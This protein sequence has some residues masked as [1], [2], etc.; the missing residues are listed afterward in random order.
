M[1]VLAGIWGGVFL[2]MRR[3]NPYYRRLGLVER[4]TTNY[5]AT[6]WPRMVAAIALMGWYAWMLAHPPHDPR[7]LYVGVGGVLIWLWFDMGR[8]LSLLYYPV[9]GLL[10]LAVGAPNR[11]FGYLLP[12]MGSAAMGNIFVGSVVLLVALL[13][14]RQLVVAL[15]RFPTPAEEPE[16]S[17]LAEETR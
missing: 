5:L 13:D 8:S 12:A 2:L 9:L 3:V 6:P 15:A 11:T 14:H 16:D 1:A 4:P 7:C 17:A 10:V